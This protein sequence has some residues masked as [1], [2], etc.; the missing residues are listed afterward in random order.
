MTGCNGHSNPV[1]SDGTS[2][3]AR[4]MQIFDSGTP[5]GDGYK[6][7]SSST[8]WVCPV[9]YGVMPGDIAVRDEGLG[10]I[11]T[12]CTAF[13]RHDSPQAPSQIY[14]AV[15]DSNGD[16]VYSANFSASSVKPRC[17]YPAVEV[18]YSREEGAMTAFIKVYV[19]WMEITEEGDWDLYQKC[20]YFHVDMWHGVNWSFAWQTPVTCIDATSTS[21]NEIHPDLCVLPASGD[22]FAVFNREYT[23][24]SGAIF[25][26]KQPWSYFYYPSVWED[27]YKVSD[28]LDLWKSAPKIDADFMHI[29]TGSGQQEW[30]RAMVAAVWAEE[31]SDDDW[32]VYYNQWY[33]LSVPSPP[34]DSITHDGQYRANGLPQIDIVPMSSWVQDHASLQA[35]VTWMYG[36]W[37]GQHY[38]SPRI[39]I[40]VTPELE[41]FITLDDEFGVAP[42][43]ACYQLPDPEQERQW[44]GV[45]YYSSQSGEDPWRTRIRSFSFQI[46]WETW[47]VSI[48]NHYDDDVPF[49][50]GQWSELTYFTGST[51]CLR[52]PEVPGDIWKQMFGIGW[53]DERDP[54]NQYMTWLSQGNIE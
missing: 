37:D 16:E 52:N 18:M 24:T 29:N 3:I 43:V 11:D 46:P 6:L 45:S 32:E 30:P 48:Q 36:A 51:L 22:L 49:S 33:H 25:A 13:V 7:D 44:F 12:L 20:F 27:P 14:L 23:A 28:D 38:T 2:A 9:P 42:D 26:I 17:R 54:D 39:R 40:G 41:N 35:V 31:V 1:E 47:V 34:I 50:Q 4:S 10:G 21:D 19:I 53:V 15:I 5:W 8:R